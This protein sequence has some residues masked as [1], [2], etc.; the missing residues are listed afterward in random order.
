MF[1][2]LAMR[3]KSPQSLCNDV[4]TVT[5]VAT[6]YQFLADQTR[7]SMFFSLWVPRQVIIRDK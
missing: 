2:L 1:V 5:H 3:G 7:E 6:A 4:L